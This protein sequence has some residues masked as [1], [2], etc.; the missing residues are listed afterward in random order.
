MLLHFFDEKVLAL[1][2]DE[3]SGLQWEPDLGQHVSKFLHKNQHHVFVFSRIV[4]SK[5]RVKEI[6]QGE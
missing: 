5:S 1:F 6:S 4:L 2:F 3:N